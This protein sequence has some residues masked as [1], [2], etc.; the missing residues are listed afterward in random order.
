LRALPRERHD[1]GDLRAGLRSAAKKAGVP[2]ALAAAA[3][4][5]G[6]APFVPTAHRGLAELGEIAGCGLIL[7]FLTSIT[8]LP[9]L[10]MVLN[11]PIEPHPMGFAALRPVDQ[12]IQ[13]YRVPVVLIT[14][15]LVVLAAPLLLF[16]PFDFNPLHLR[17]PNVESVATFLDLRKD[18]QTGANAIEIIAPNLGAADAIGKR[19]A[20]LPQV[21]QGGTLSRLIPAD[22]DQKR[23]LI[24]HAAEALK[25]SINPTE[26]S[27]PPTDEQ[28]I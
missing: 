20:S 18:P 1:Y 14:L 17:N 11:T 24:Q 26:V 25:S 22:Q 21:S 2:L 9:A 19:L 28:N 4:A 7:A 12:F 23:A 15:L 16:L 27:P 6:F 10:L 13:R 3:T 5:V 8:L